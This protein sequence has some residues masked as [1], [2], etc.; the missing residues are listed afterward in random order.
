MPFVDRLGVPASW[1]ARRYTRPLPQ[2]DGTLRL[3]GLDAPVEVLRDRWGV[4]HIYGERID[5]V[6]T[7]QGFV[8]AQDR[9]WQMEL[10]RR[11]GHGRLSELFGAIAYGTD[12]LLRKIG[13][14]RAARATLGA[15]DP[16][17]LRLLH[18]YACGVNAF[19]DGGHRP[20]ELVLLNVRP[21]PWQPLD[22]L[23]WIQMM[24]WGLSTNWDT[25]LLRAAFVARVGEARAARLKGEYP[26]DNPIVIPGETWSATL[27]AVVAELEAARPWL[28]IG[29]FAGMSN[30]WV[31]DGT[32]S[33]SGKP[34]LANDPHLSPQLPSIWYENHLVAVDLHVAGV[35]LPGA[36]GVVI[37]HNEDLAWGLTSA[38]TDVQ[39]LYLEE[40]DGNGN[41]RTEHGWAPLTVEREEISVRGEE[42]PRVAEVVLTRHGPLINELTP[43][44]DR[45]SHAVPAIA[46]RWIGHEPSHAPRAILGVNRARDWDEFTR[47]LADWTAPPMNVVY[48]DTRGNIGY[49]TVGKTPIRARGRGLVPVPGWS[50]EHEWIGYVPHDEMP[51]VFNPPSHVLASANNPIVGGGH[52]HFLAADTMNGFRVRRVLQ[53][54]G[55]RDQLTLDDF[56]RIQIDQYCA[57]A[58][59]FCALVG[60]LR[61]GILA[62]SPLPTLAARALDALAGWD[63]VLSADSVAGAIYELTLHFAMRRLFEPWLGELTEHYL[64]AGFH[65]VINPV[66]ASLLDG[67]PL[68]A[69]D[70]LARDERDWLRD[71]TRAQLLARALDDALHFLEQACGPVLE[72]WQWGRVHPIAFLHPLGAQKPLDC[73]FN[74][75]PYPYGGD[76][77]TVWQASWVPRLPIRSD[78]GFTAS[79]RQLLDVGDWDAARGVHAPGQSGHPA[80]PHYDDLV[81][82]W[83][84]GEYHPMLWSRARVELYAEAKLD[85]TP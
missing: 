37:G 7:A 32:R 57:P 64:G 69:L 71:Q 42:R 50:G 48:A 55:E 73:V 15:L 80:S 39:D 26:R 17:T 31:V 30:N 29:A 59:P 76:A 27:D 25:E 9:F 16:E 3:P 46:L 40:L 24:A 52:R 22:S 61:A 54:L 75:G 20:L 4:P 63:Q 23:A 53:L 44:T 41:Y 33:A 72:D 51:R 11:I 66:I 5:D 84:R 83:L 67:T 62:A 21:E 8:H 74:R 2:V 56:A 70:I 1:L 77:N 13:L 19:L 34:L 79:W 14:H 38:F 43:L 36:P 60:E 18:A 10:N 65:P 82:P 68:V 47:A 35:S 85:L 6:I 78:G 49:H 28:P 58:A 12:R 45:R 81:R